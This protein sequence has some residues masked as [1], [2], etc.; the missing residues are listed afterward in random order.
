MR[1]CSDAALAAR[2]PLHIL[3]MLQVLEGLD[4]AT[5]F[6]HTSLHDRCQKL[7]FSK[8]TS[9]QAGAPLPSRHA[10]RIVLRTMADEL[11][12]QQILSSAIGG[13]WIEGTV[14][15]KVLRA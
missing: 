7:S 4:S 3:S 14:L 1:T 2:V 9:E 13:K 8:L 10:S 12:E 6:A 15:Y 11:A 5:Y